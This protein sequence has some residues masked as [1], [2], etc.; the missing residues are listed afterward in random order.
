MT[1][2]I[3]ENP[4]T[5]KLYLFQGRRMLILRR[6]LSSHPFKKSLLFC[7]CCHDIPP[8]YRANLWSA[9]LNIYWD[10]EKRFVAVDT[11]S[12]HASDRQLLVDIPRCHQ[13]MFQRQLYKN[14]FHCY[15]SL[16]KEKLLYSVTFHYMRFG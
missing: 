8:L 5:H 11:F 2:F 6:L 13:V 3:F 9:L 12:P 4:S 16:C 7:E 15:I 1:D 14:V 10:V